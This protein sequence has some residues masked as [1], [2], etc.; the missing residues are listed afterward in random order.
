MFTSP[1]VRSKPPPAVTLPL[2][3]RAHRVTEAADDRLCFSNAPRRGN[4]T[5]AVNTRSDAVAEINPCFSF[6]APCRYPLYVSG[7]RDRAYH[8]PPNTRKK[9]VLRYRVRLPPYVTCTQCVMQWTYYTGTSGTR[10]RDAPF[11]PSVHNPP[12]YFVLLLDRITRSVVVVVEKAAGGSRAPC[13][14]GR[15]PA[16]AG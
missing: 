2:H 13:S 11:H 14:I 5:P 10:N 1:R 8:I 7:T 4:K 12:F 3:H 6:F 16:G 9:A 15:T